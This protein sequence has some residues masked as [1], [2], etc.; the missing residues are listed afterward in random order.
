MHTEHYEGFLAIQKT[1]HENAPFFI[2][3]TSGGET[4][5]CGYALSKTPIPQY[6]FQVLLLNAGIQ[7]QSMEDVKAYVKKYDT[8]IRN[9]TILGTWGG[10][11]YI[12]AKEYYD[13]IDRAMPSKKKIDAQSIEPYYFMDF[14][15]YT[16]HQYFEN[17]KV[18]IITSH[19]KT[20]EQQIA[21]G[22]VNRVYKKPIFH[23]STEFRVYK[24]AQQNAGSHDQNSWVFHHE[25]MKRELTDLKKEFDFDIALVSAGGFGM[26]LCDFIFTELKTSV[27]YVGGAL[28]L[29]FGIRG[30]RW[31]SS[32]FF[33][34]SINDAWTDVLDIDKPANI[35]LCERG[36]YW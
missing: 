21:N 15:E 24:P 11:M 17:K 6:L 30:K 7:I 34:E 29:F 32:K 8:A 27:I 26:I 9:T 3:R 2:G 31:E 12:Q 18:L 35:E 16:Y 1:M 10:S 5:F 25:N 28:Q 36:C 13:Y 4:Q 23:V 33:Q 22:N 20:V 19:S 14:P